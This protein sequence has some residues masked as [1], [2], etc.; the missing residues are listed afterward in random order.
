[1]SALRPA[2][3]EVEVELGF[4]VDGSQVLDYHPSRAGGPVGTL[5]GRRELRAVR[6]RNA[7]LRRC[8]LASCGFELRT[9]PSRVTDFSHP[10]TLERIYCAEIERLLL[11]ATG[12]RQVL[13]FDHTR[14]ADDP[15]LRARQGVREPSSTAH[16]DYTEHSARR[17]LT[18]LLPAADAARWLAGDWAIINVWRPLSGSAEGAPLALCDART[19]SEADLVTA[20]R[21]TPERSGELYYL[22]WNAAQHW[23]WFANMSPSE[24]VLFKTFDS[25]PTEA[26]RFTPHTAFRRPEEGRRLPPRQSIESRAL[27]LL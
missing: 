20:R 1:M 27:V 8:S 15:G 4:V 9:H 12:A 21:L 3:D 18:A 10:A 5:S 7:R 25:R 13:V 24:V 2:P 17:R 6:L 23:L 11:T 19:V 14:R 16:N 22:A 26:A